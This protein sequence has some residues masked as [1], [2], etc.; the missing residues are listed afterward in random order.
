MTIKELRTRTGLTQT[1]ICQL[2]GVPMRTWQGWELGER[3]APDYVVK[4][5]AYFLEKEGKIKNNS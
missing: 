4:L 3:K 1:K 2:T 5:I